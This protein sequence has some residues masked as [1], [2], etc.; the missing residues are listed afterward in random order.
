MSR[1]KVDNIET[2]SGNNVSMDNAL[3]LKS[4]T[5]SQRDALS[6]PQAGWTILNSTTGKLNF[7]TGSAW[8]AVTSS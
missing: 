8:E 3:K 2:R 4:Y 5:T 7:Y 1:L 6:S